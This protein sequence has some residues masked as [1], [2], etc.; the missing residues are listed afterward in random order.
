[1][2]QSIKCT[3][4]GSVLKSPKPVEAGKKLKCPKCAKVFVVA[5]DEEEPEAEEESAAEESAEEEETPKK[6][7]KAAAKDDDE[8]DEDE[9]PK[10]KPGKDKKSKKD[11]APKKGSNMLLIAGIGG[12]LLLCCCAGGGGGTCLL[13]PSKDKDTPIA[14]DGGKDKKA[15]KGL[16]KGP[17]K[18]LDKGSDKGLDK[19]VIDKV[20]NVGE[21]K[22]EVFIDAQVFLKEFAADKDAAWKKIDGKVIEVTGQVKEVRVRWGFPLKNFTAGLFDPYFDVHLQPDQ[23][24]KV[25]RLAP[26][27][28]VKIVGRRPSEFNSAISLHDCLLTELEPSNIP[29]VSAEALMKEARANSFGIRDKYKPTDVIVT[30]V[31]ES[32]DKNRNLAIMKGQG[33]ANWDISLASGEID[34]VKQG[35]EVELRC[36]VGFIDDRKAKKGASLELSDGIFVRKIK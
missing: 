21:L 5:E 31:V 16:A 36:R 34:R 7:G 15:D 35:D 9:K 32:L 11:D 27:T 29:V 30:G 8:D 14:Q 3:H 10:K 20:P 19:I 2:S 6:K 22:A 26:N 24:D 12:V 25:T 18:G 4:C 1:M 28:K 17:D 23:Q 33:T 13:W